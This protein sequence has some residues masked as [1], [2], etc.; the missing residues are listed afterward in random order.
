MPEKVWMGEATMN[1]WIDLV[2][3]P[4]NNSKAQG[5]I[6]IITLDAYHLHMMGMIV[7]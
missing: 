7:N 3:V 5:A 4:W 1:K 2:F 6:P